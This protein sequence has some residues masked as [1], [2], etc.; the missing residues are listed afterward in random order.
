LAE[1]HR[2]FGR[3]SGVVH[4]VIYDE[5]GRGAQGVILGRTEIPLLIKEKDS[6]VPVVDT[7]ALQVAAVDFALG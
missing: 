5:L 3:A 6:P 7:T 1:L 2:D 4:W